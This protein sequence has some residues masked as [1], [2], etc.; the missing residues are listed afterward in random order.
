M[1][2]ENI[3]VG[4]K[5]TTPND[6]QQGA[7]GPG[8]IKAIVHALKEQAA[9]DGAILQMLK[10][11]GVPDDEAQKYLD[12]SKATL[13]PQVQPKPNP[14]PDNRKE[15][16]QQHGIRE[17]DVGDFF[18]APREVVELP[19]GGHWYDGKNTVTIK[20]LTATEDDLLYDA[21]LIEKNEVMNSI[22]DKAVLDKDLRPKDMLTCDRDYLLIKLR[23][24]GLGDDY[25][26]DVRPCTKCG[27]IYQPT[28]DLSKLKIRPIKY[29]PDG[30]QEFTL[31]MKHMPADIKFRLLNGRDEA[32][33]NKKAL[34]A[35]SMGKFNLGS[36]LT[37]KYVLHIMEV[38][39][40]RD[41]TY[42]KSYVGAMP[43]KDSKFFR[44]QL[45]EK[46]PGLDMNYDFEC[47][48]CGHVDRKPVVI[49][50]KL[51]YPDAEL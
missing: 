11:S 3:K 15:V 6:T 42:I 30:N 27:Y 51:F 17:E 41:K 35:R 36:S 44:E 10:N 20:H 19:S 47:P 33:I 9:D 2:D 32:R 8:E 40:K 14:A 39:G 7:M 18:E 1:S 31:R 25:L 34:A 29:T 21:S 49:T 43:M 4:H 37:D 38:N 46:S 45:Q 26:A 28:V 24:T 5:G 50:Y 22:L 12:E 48:N 23:Q 16:A 13:E